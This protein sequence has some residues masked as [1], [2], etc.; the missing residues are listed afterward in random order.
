MGPHPERICPLAQRCRCREHPDRFLDG[1]GFTRQ[2]C[3]IHKEILGFLDQTVSGDDP[4]GVQNDHISGDDLFD[5]NLS[6][7]SIAQHRRLD[8]YDG[9][10]LLHGVCCAP[11]LPKPEQAACED[12]CQNNEGVNRIA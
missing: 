7:A 12:N 4:A 9:E 3:L 2:R 6:G 10:Q 1:V 8:L 5:G 11:F